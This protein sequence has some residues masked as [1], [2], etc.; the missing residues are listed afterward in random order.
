MITDVSERVFQLQEAGYAL[1]Q[2]DATG[3]VSADPERII[4]GTGINAAGRNVLDSTK[5]DGL[6]LSF[7]DYSAI[8]LDKRQEA[9]D[10]VAVERTDAATRLFFV[11]VPSTVIADMRSGNMPSALHFHIL[12][13]PPTWESCYVRTPYWDGRC[14]RWTPTYDREKDVCVPDMDKQPI[15]VRLGLRYAS[16]YSLAVPHHLVAQTGRHPRV[17]YIAPV[18]SNR[19]FADLQ[20]SRGILSALGEIADFLSGRETNGKATKYS[21]AIGQ[22]TVSGYSRSGTHLA[23]LMR[24]LSSRDPFFINNLTQVNAFDINLGNNQGEREA[25]FNPL[26]DALFRWKS[27]VNKKAR[28]CIYTAY[29]YHADYVLRGSRGTLS[30]PTRVDLDSVKWTNEALRNAQ[31]TPRGQ[32][33]EAYNSDGSVALVHLPSTFA[34]VYLGPVRN[35]RGYIPVPNG[36][37]HNWFLRALMSHALAHG[38]PAGFGSSR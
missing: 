33:L 22:V 6:N 25:S 35:A 14:P 11:W 13:H 2:R 38:D 37:G 5:P 34:N 24:Q 15:Y 32:G 29:R 19:D 36:N 3:R 18:A 8:K 4:P 7:I 31:G 30:S 12:Y 28:I 17:I 27:S 23:A 20:S 1:F 16:Q 21:G 26:C 10:L 9:G